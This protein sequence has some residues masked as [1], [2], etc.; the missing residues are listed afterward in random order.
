METQAVDPI[1]R[2]GELAGTADRSPIAF[3]YLAQTG[4]ADND[5]LTGLAPIFRPLAR[6][7]VGER[8][9]PSEFA[10]NVG[11]I[12]GLKVH[13]WAVEDLAPR[14]ERVGLLQKVQV[15]QGVHEYI[16]AEVG[17]EFSDVSEADI[18]LVVRRFVDFAKPLL[19]GHGLDESDDRLADAFL[20][21]LVDMDFVAVLLRPDQSADKERKTTT[22]TLKKPVDQVKWE[23]ESTIQARFNVLCASFILEVHRNDRPLYDLLAGN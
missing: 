21:H 18:R 10:E 20:R 4:R 8:F 9:D 16:Y 11:T 15:A 1:A 17:D 3:A 23:A 13:P 5:I 12:F 14:L 6:G 22:L 19:M 7:R 2:A